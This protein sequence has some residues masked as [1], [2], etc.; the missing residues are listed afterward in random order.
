MSRYQELSRK[1]DDCA[2]LSRAQQS[3]LNPILPGDAP[4]YGDNARSM[5]PVEM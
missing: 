3:K 5:P 4:F 2:Q 1:R